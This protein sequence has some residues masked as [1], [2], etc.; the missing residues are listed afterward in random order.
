MT[1]TS[2]TSY[3]NTNSHSAQELFSQFSNMPLKDFVLRLKSFEQRLRNQHML[4]TNIFQHTQYDPR[5]ISI[6]MNSFQ[7]KQSAFPFY[8]RQAIDAVMQH[9][10]YISHIS[11]NQNP[12]KINNNYS[13]LARKLVDRNSLLEAIYRL[14]TDELENNPNQI[15]DEAEETVIALTNNEG[16]TRQNYFEGLN[17]LWN[18][19]LYFIS[20]N[21]P[22][23]LL[24]A[25]L[26]YTDLISPINQALTSKYIID[27]FIEKNPETVS[28]AKN[29]LKDIPMNKELKTNYRMVIK[30]TLVV[31][32]R[33]KTKS[34][35]AYVLDK[36]SIVFVEEKKK[37]WSKVLF[38]NEAG[39]DQSGW[40]Y[41]R[42]IK[43]LD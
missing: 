13:L 39:E 6:T 29:V 37:N 16:I 34:N 2:L 27:E 23:L 4:G 15:M 32:T 38:R 25:N 36:S 9:F 19:V 43:K 7:Q 17:R 41:T 22:A 10:S 12:S 5:T 24:L 31:R 11:V 40:V 42:Y 14:N 3:W 35:V 18:T 20:K 8:S 21:T 26:I 1:N 30:D 33:P 28:E